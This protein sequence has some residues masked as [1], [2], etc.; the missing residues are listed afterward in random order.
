[1][2]LLETLRR[3]VCEANRNLERH[4]L[5]VMTWGNVSG[6]DRTQ[7]LM[8][9]KPSGVPYAE[10]TP[11]NMVVVDEHGKP[12]EKGLQ[13]SSDAPSHLVL[14]KAFPAIGGITHTHSTHATM[15]AQAC[16]P[17]PCFGTTHADHFYGEVPVTR[18]L[19]KR[20]I[21]EGYERNT[22]VVIVEQ[23]IRRDPATM[24][25]ALVAHHGPFT[26]G[27]T[28]RAAVENGVALEECARMALGSLQLAPTLSAIP[29]MLLDKHFLRKHGPTAYY[30][31]R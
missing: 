10:L 30:G 3:D 22:G 7:R 28:P 18:A 11:E 8:V 12:V 9:I 20:E 29:D 19:R 15:F 25:A 27:S 24:P 21:E 13:P 26:W 2:M 4:N 14:Y 1:M 6:F 16:R 23:F 5:V 17:I 31:Q